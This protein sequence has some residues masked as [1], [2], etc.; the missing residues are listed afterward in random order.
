MAS[1]PA[2]VPADLFDQRHYLAVRQPLQQAETLP[3]WCYTSAEFHRREIEQVFMRVWNLVGRVDQIPTPG[4][5]FSIDIGGESLI[6]VRENAEHIHAFANTCRHRGTRLVPA[7]GHCRVFSCPYHSWAYA[8]DGRLIATPGMED[9]ADFDRAANGLL[10]VALDIWAGF[11]FV[12]LSGAGETLAAYLGN[13]PEKLE[14]YNFA[15]VECVR[16]VEYEV[17]CNW[18]LWVENALEDYHTPTVHRTSIGE[19]VTMREQTTENWDAIH[20]ESEVT[21][22]VLPEDNSPFPHIAGLRGKPAEGTYFIV[23]YPSTVLACTQD[24]MWWNQL[25]PRGPGRSTMVVAACFPRTTVERPDFEQEVQKYY[26]R[27]D[28]SIPEDNAICEEQQAGLS[29][30]FARPGRMSVREPVVHAID[31]WILDRVVS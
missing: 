8:L 5:Y 15:D 10:E 17:A 14:S 12:N 16:R 31:N 11:I 28:R 9:T 4:D 30:V 18:K 2:Q 26:E 24:C 23:L 7:S 27:W 20:M 22:A 13:L 25:L 21:V 19:Q 29:S 1:V 6:I 3:A